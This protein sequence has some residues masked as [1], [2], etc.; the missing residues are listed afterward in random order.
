MEVVTC[1]YFLFS[2]TTVS[3]WTTTWLF[4]ER[5][6]NKSNVWI[7]LEYTDWSTL[8]DESD[9][10]WL[11][12]CFSLRCRFVDFTWRTRIIANLSAKTSSSSRF[13]MIEKRT[14]CI[15]KKTLSDAKIKSQ[16]LT[17]INNYIW[18]IFECFLAQDCSSSCGR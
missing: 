6:E 11:I 2:I 4:N 7:V 9:Q 18:T 16:L 3:T 17:S 5:W 10:C 15:W 13:D 12:N 8:Y 14:E 1:R